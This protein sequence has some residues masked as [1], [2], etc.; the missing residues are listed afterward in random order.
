MAK[1]DKK[2]KKGGLDLIWLSILPVLLVLSILLALSI[3]SK[4]ENVLVDKLGEE[5]SNK[6]TIEDIYGILE[7]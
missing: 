3:W 2:K 1:K 4:T 6:P 7:E 5:A